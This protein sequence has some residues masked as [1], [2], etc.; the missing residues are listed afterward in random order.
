[1]IIEE[2]YPNRVSDLFCKIELGIYLSSDRCMFRGSLG[3]YLS[4]DRCM[5][6]G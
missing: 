6:R 4:S 1:M 3:I 2:A 5:F